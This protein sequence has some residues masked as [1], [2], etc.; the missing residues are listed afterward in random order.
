MRQ[1]KQNEFWTKA[2]VSLSKVVEPHPQKN[3]EVVRSAVGFCRKG[4][5]TAADVERVAV[6]VGAAE[7]PS[8]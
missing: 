4:L 6:A 8:G 2:L 7:K 5:I 1:S 3:E